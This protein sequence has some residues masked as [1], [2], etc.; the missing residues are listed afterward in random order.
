MLAENFNSQRRTQF[1]EQTIEALAECQL[2][3]L[4][5]S[6]QR[7]FGPFLTRTFP[8][9]APDENEHQG[10]QNGEN[11]ACIE[12]G[13]RIVFTEMREQYPGQKGGQNG[14]H[15]RHGNTRPG[16][17]GFLFEVIGHFRHQRLVRHQ[18]HGV[19]NIKHQISQQVIPEI[20]VPH[21][22]QRVAE[23]ARDPQQNKE[24][25][26]TKALS[27]PGRTEVVRQEPH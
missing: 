27:E 21:P 14:G 13:D 24:F 23:Y 8:G 7:R 26:A 17:L 16:E 19:D 20:H 1:H 4:F 3:L 6:P 11:Q 25:T 5:F 22:H 10:A 12:E 15:L 9:K 18:N 2:L